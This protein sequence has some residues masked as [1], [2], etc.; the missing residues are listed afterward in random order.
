MM[1]GG[2]LRSFNAEYKRRREAAGGHFMSYRAAQTRL[3][4]AIVP[5]LIAGGSVGQSLFEE[6]F[7]R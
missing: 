7:G 2:G 5:R 3:R 1:A 6:I 4:R